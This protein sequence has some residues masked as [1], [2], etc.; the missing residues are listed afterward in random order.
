MTTY[1][2]FL[3]VLREFNA[4]QKEYDV[5]ERLQLFE[6]YLNE[7]KSLLDAFMQ[8]AMSASGKGT[9]QTTNKAINEHTQRTAN[10]MVMYYFRL[11]NRAAVNN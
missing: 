11:H 2:E 3:R 4:P 8:A 1:I 9:E 5:I 6:E 10:K 7:K